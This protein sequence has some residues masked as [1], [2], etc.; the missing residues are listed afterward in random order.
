[1]S[2][3]GNILQFARYLSEQRM[4][5]STQTTIQ[6]AVA[7]LRATEMDK[8]VTFIVDMA[9]QGMS[10]VLEEVQIISNTDANSTY[11]WHSISQFSCRNLSGDCLCVST[12]TSVMTIKHY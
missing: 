7:Q 4:L 12:I 8:H 11:L 3:A 1:V 2:K 9:C 10:A 5:L 6:D